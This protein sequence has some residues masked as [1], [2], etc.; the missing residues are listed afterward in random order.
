[1]LV[2][3]LANIW[4]ALPLL[5]AA[6]FT[7]YFFRDPEREI[8]SG[9]VAVSPADGRVVD[10][11]DVEHEGLPFRRV[12]IFLNVFDVHVNRSPVTGVIRQVE[13]ATGKFLVASRLEASTENERNMVVVDGPDGAVIFKQIAGIVAR[14]IVFWKKEGD[15]VQKGERV[16]LMKFGSRVDV[17]FDA[18]WE[19]AVAEGQRVAGGSSILARRRS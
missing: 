11:R 7:M 6:L 4:F 8:P 13:Y 14:R 16:G 15:A 5:A 10:I 18:N 1:M 2:W 17:F 9:P 19:V 12:A 3:W